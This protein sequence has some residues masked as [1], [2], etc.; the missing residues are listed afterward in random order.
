LLVSLAV[1]GA[2]LALPYTPLA[3]PLGF[4]PLPPRV[5]VSLLAIVVAYFATA[6]VVKHWFYTRYSV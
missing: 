1:A 6:E 2:A 5:L 4:A 3:G